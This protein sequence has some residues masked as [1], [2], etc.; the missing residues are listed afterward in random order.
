MMATRSIIAQSRSRMRVDGDG[1]SD[2]DII[3]FCLE[4]LS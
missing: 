3:T 2:D 1:G 4:S